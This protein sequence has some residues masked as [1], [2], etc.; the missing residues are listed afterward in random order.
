MKL[1]VTCYAKPEVGDT[2]RFTLDE[3]VDFG[4]YHNATIY[5]GKVYDKTDTQITVKCGVFIITGPIGVFEL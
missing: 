4:D 3:I 5:T 1:V 2:V